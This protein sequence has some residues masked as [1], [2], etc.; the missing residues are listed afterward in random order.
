MENDIPRSKDSKP[1]PKKAKKSF[2]KLVNWK[3][4]VTA[5][6]SSLSISMVLSLLSSEG[7]NYLNVFCSCLVLV[8]FIA[9]GVIFDII[10]L[11]VATADPKPFLAM[12]ARKVRAGKMAVR[13]I[14]NAD[15]VSSFCNEVIGDICGVVSG[16]TAAAVAIKM[17]TSENGGFW[18]GVVIGGLV[19]AFTVGSK[20][21]GKAA[22]LN[23][24]NE[25]VMAVAKILSVF[26]KNEKKAKYTKKPSKNSEE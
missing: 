1:S 18:L 10:G 25:I 22:G 16:S 12:A 24:S 11:S 20:A 8:F 15:R 4:S 14:K 13:L 6:L 2:W 3:W 9:L 26:S 23:F 5:F 7:L 17:A 19:S 21:V